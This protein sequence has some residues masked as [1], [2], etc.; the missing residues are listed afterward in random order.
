MADALDV[1]CPDCG[2]PPKT[3]CYTSSASVSSATHINR[4]DAA[5]L[6]RGTCALCSRPMYRLHGRRWHAEGF[7][8]C[9]PLPDPQTDWNAYA[10]KVNEGMAQGDPGD[11]AFLPAEAT[12][13]PECKAGKHP[14]CDGTTL[15]PDDSMGPCTCTD[16]AHNPPE[17]AD[18]IVSGWRG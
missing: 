13:C 6:E 17:D 4:E 2:A 18:E 12:T 8:G 9:P 11:A 3:E 5:A 7:V 15:C 16:D 14:N 10:A 1:Q